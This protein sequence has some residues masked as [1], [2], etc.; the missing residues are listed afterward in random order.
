MPIPQILIDIKKHL[1]SEK[2]CFSKQTLDGRTNS[3]MDEKTVVEILLNKFPDCIKEQK[4]R[5]WFDIAVKHNDIYLPV[6]IK[7]TTMKSADNVGNLAACVM[8]YTDTKLELNKDYQNGKL[9]K[10]LLKSLNEG[11]FNNDCNKDYWFL[12]INKINGKVVINS[13]LGLTHITPNLNNLPF[14]IKWSNNRE[15]VEKPIMESIIKFITALQKPKRTWQMEFIEGI[16]KLKI[17]E[18]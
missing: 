3:C 15:W 7:I 14:Q 6:N 12:V 13:M 18:S 4:I 16:N 17:V 8:A 9:S 11:K 10:I 2:I 5:H 1:E